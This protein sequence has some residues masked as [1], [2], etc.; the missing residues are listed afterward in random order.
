MYI[1][2]YFGLKLVLSHTFLKDGTKVFEIKPPLNN[3]KYFVFN[4]KMLHK[5]RFE[6]DLETSNFTKNL[7]NSFFTFHFRNVA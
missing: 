7:K 5:N 1:P 4:S 3:H 2:N 6:L